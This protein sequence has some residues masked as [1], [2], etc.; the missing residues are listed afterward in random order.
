[1]TYPPDFTY[2]HEKLAT[3]A[4][5]AQSIA[6]LASGHRGVVQAGGCSGMWPLA[7][8][9]YFERVYTFEPE[10]MNVQCLRANVADARN[11]SASACAVGD[12][13][14]SVGLTRPKVQA[15]LWRV[16]GDGDIPMVRLDDVVDDAVDAIVLDVEGFEV[17]ALRGAERLIAEHRPLLWFEFLHHIEAIEAFLAA[18][19]YMKPMHGMGGD[20]YSIHATRVQ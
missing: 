4:R 14:A 13:R 20:C 3:A 11:I 12:R 5:A 16:D 1:M 6:G 2:P 18:H 17:Q 7:L 9:P 10:P 19:G 8:A 15:G